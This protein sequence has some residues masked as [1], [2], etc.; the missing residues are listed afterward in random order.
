MQQPLIH[1]GY[2]KTASTFLQREVF[3]NARV[4]H[5]PW[6]AQSAL[7]IEHF[8]L[9]H[10]ARFDPAIIR[11]SVD[12]PDGLVPVISHEDLLG[13]PVH[14]RYYAQATV[15]RIAETFPDARIL[16]CIR[17]Q[18]SMLFSNYLQYI[19]QGGTKTLTD[20]L[21]ANSGRPG[22][23][24]MFRLDHF[25]YD[26]THALLSE[27]FAEDRIL[28]LPLETLRAD[29]AGFMQRLGAF[30]GSDLSDVAPHK[31][32]N[33]HRGAPAVL[34]ER[35]LNRFTP[36]PASLPERY[37]EYPLGIRLRNRVVRWT[38]RLIRLPSVDR[39]IF[40]RLEAEIDAHVGP[41]FAQSNARMA[42]ITGLPLSDYGYRV[43]PQI[44]GR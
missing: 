41:Y 1:L 13:Y 25:E 35:F 40:Q 19:R 20:M 43:A 8:H 4:F 3:S 21:G 22:F 37:A 28:V 18:N 26:L 31:T 42:A 32:V 36:D 34:L 12:T 9:C 17:E 29:L 15:R 24:P 44:G 5:A 39:R 11:A 16:I 23:R 27:H 38:D 30:V 33:A 7:A 6:G 10:P 2:Q 14:G